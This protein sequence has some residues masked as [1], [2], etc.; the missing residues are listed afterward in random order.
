[1]ERKSLLPRAARACL[2][3]PSAVVPRSALPGQG[4][5]AKVER[6]AGRTTFA[7][8][9][10]SGRSPIGTAA[11]GKLGLSTSTLG[12]RHGLGR[13]FPEPE[14]PRR[15]QKRTSATWWPVVWA[16]A[17]PGGPPAAGERGGGGRMRGPARPPGDRRPRRTL[18]AARRGAAPAAQAPPPLDPKQPNSARVVFPSR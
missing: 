1:A 18:R 8:W 10:W 9:P 2:S 11:D 6:P 16:A 7:P 17:R 5:G 4:Q 3:F 12:D 14:C 15:R 13:G